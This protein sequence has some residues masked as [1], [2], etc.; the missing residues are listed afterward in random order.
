MTMK[1]KTTKPTRNFLTDQKVDKVKRNADWHSLCS[2]EPVSSSVESDDS[3]RPDDI[4]LKYLFLPITTQST[5]PSIEESINTGNVATPTDSLPQGW[6]GL[7][8]PAMEQALDMLL[9]V[10]PPNYGGYKT[11][12]PDRPKKITL[13]FLLKMFVVVPFIVGYLVVSVVADFIHML[14]HELSESDKRLLSKSTNRSE[15]MIRHDGSAES[16]EPRG[17]STMKHNGR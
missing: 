3:Q 1:H 14:T 16:P 11:Q 2:R 5:A 12:P 4:T 8:F 7:F 9:R 6:H 17:Q 10:L 13:A 15:Q